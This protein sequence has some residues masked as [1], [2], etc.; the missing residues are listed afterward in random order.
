M[1]LHEDKTLI[2]NDNTREIKNKS[3][4]QINKQQSSTYGR[5]FKGSVKNVSRE[6]TLNGAQRVRRAQPEQKDFNLNKDDKVAEYDTETLLSYWNT[7]WKKKSL[8]RRCYNGIADMLRRTTPLICV[9][10]LLFYLFMIFLQ[11]YICPSSVLDAISAEERQSSGCGCN[12][13]SHAV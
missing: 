9:Y 2:P 7:S 3:V 5:R 4:N 12:S 11:A 10:L 8:A 13:I 6:L 1:S